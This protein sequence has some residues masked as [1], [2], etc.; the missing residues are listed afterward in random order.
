MSKASF[1]S[2]VNSKVPVLIDFYA[3]W[4]GP[5]KMLSPII[6]EIKTDF[7]KKLRVIKIDVDKNKAL[8]QMLEIMSMPTIMLYR[9]GEIIWRTVG[10]QTKQAITSKVQELLD[11]N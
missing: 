7:G 10:V 2:I 1:Q 11:S 6:K 4:C 5:C 8:T 9:N 3:T